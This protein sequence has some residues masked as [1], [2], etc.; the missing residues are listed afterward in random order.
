MLGKKR[1]NKN[2]L[3]NFLGIRVQV[4]GKIWPNEICYALFCF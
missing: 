1:T 3:V 2:S 4:A